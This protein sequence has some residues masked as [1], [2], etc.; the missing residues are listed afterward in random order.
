M[1]Y[2]ALFGSG[3]NHASGCVCSACDRLNCYMDMQYARESKA[4]P[5]RVNRQ[6]RLC[7]IIDGAAHRRM[8]RR[9]ATQAQSGEPSEEYVTCIDN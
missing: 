3:K 4:W 1:K 8:F 7:D 9:Q 5:S 2:L 6:G